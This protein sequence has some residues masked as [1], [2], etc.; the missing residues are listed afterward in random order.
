MSAG[1]QIRAVAPVFLVADVKRAA[2]YYEDALGFRVPRFWGEP[3][4]F[5]IAGR[6]GV[7]VM[8]NQVGIPDLVHANAAQNGRFDAYFHVRDADVLY[9]ELSERGADI[10][11][12]PED[13][14]Y[15]MREFQVR[16]PDGH[17]IA[18]GHDLSESAS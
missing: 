3:P 5:A 16:D 2:A 6:D 12:A 18:F 9:A 1:P 7:E 14:E 11:C 8:L 15:Q 13:F 17:L 4:S 10:V